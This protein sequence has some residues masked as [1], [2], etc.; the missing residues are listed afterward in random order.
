MSEYP[1]TVL[2]TPFGAVE[3]TALGGGALYIK[4]A[5]VLTINSVEYTASIH[6]FND[7]KAEENSAGRVAPGWTLANDR[8]RAPASAL[9]YISQG[10]RRR[11][12]IDAAHDQVTAA[13]ARAFRDQ[14][15]P[16]V[17]GWAESPE[18]VETRRLGVL[19]DLGNEGRRVNEDLEKNTEERRRLC[20]RLN[21]LRRLA[22]QAS[23]Q[24]YNPFGWPPAAG[25]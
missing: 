14:V 7:P 6:L 8:G 20:E 10:V 24:G 25:V 11:N 22:T 13:G 2:V 23:R 9:Y 21:E 5:G 4:A 17:I 19:A 18:G 3:V 1:T 15:L 12:W 16:V